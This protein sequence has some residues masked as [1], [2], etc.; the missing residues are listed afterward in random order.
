ERNKYQ[1]ILASLDVRLR[2]AVTL[3]SDYLRANPDDRFAQ[4]SLASWSIMLGD[5]ARARILAEGLA[6]VDSLGTGNEPM[7]IM[8]RARDAHRAVELAWQA[9]AQDPDSVEIVYQVHRVLLSAGAT[10]D[11]ARLLPMLLASS[12][13]GSSKQMLRIRQACA[14]GRTADAVAL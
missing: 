7:Y 10:A 12:L 3:M 13:P 1:A 8:L 5:F 6:K 11:A 2:D 9:L 4:D 14:E